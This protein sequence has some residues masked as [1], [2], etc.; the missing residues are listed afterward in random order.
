M[1]GVS[2]R[3]LHHYDELG[4]L[5]PAEVGAN[6]YRYYGREELLRLQQILLHRE[7]EFPLE[8]IGEIL[9]A[10]SFDRLE[11]LRRQRRVLID[12]ADRYV[13]LIE[14]LDATLAELQGETA[15][16]DVDLY[17]GFAPEKQAE[18]EAW[19]IDLGGDCMKDAIEAS[20]AHMSQC[21]AGNFRKAMAQWDEIEVQLAKALV[22]GLPVDSETVRNLTRRHYD[23]IGGAWGRRPEP[24]SYLGL[25]AIYLEHP[26]F[27]AKFDGRQDGLAEYLVA[28]MT[29]FAEAELRELS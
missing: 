10:P 6:G 20:R 25:G 9:S 5:K 19:L 24:A 17:K 1:A 13:T 4:L 11:T 23:W 16:D 3:T 8:A 2:V 14:T 29:S 7:L 15:M 28:A 27:R 12:R 22:D 26:D 21:G 18:Y